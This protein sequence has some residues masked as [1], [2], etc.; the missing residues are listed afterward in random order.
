VLGLLVDSRGDWVLPGCV[1]QYCSQQPAWARYAFGDADSVCL[2]YKPAV[3]VH[4]YVPSLACGIVR[5]KQVHEV[6]HG[7]L[8]G[9]VGRR[10]RFIDVPMV[11]GVGRWLSLLRWSSLVTDEELLVGWDVCFVWVFGACLSLLVIRWK[12]QGVIGWVTDRARWL[13][14]GDVVKRGRVGAHLRARAE[15]LGLD[16]ELLSYLSGCVSFKLRDSRTASSLMSSGRAWVAK[17]RKKWDEHK[18]TT[19]LSEAVIEAVAIGTVEDTAFRLWGTGVVYRGIARAT[20]LARGFLN[21]G[22]ELDQ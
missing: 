22:R 11:R 6:L 4:T 1:T 3:S 16:L 18:Q 7:Y 14:Y 17:N 20:G 9:W 8:P 19:Q 10:L 5:Y 21:W 2:T 12:A 13:V 15:K